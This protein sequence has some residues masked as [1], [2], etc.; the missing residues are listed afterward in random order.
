MSVLDDTITILNIENLP[1]LS[2]ERQVGG[3]DCL[4]QN[5]NRLNT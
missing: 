2:E 5:G 3:F 4:Y 1:G